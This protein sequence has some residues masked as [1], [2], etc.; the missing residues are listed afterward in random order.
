MS[1]HSF[2]VSV[3]VVA[4][5]LFGGI[6]A[7]S[8]EMPSH[9]ELPPSLEISLFAQEPDI[10]DPVAICFDAASRMFVVEMRDYPLGIPPKNEPGGTIRLLEDTDHDGHADRS[11]LFADHLSYPTSIVPFRDGVIVAAPPEIILLRDTNHDGKAD[12]REVLCRGFNRRATDSNTSGLRWG[13]DNWLHGVNGG[14]GGDIVSTRKPA[15]ALRLGNLDFRMR[16]DSGEIET[17]FTTGGGFGLVFDQWGR[18]FTPH[19]VNHV[20]MRIMAERW[21]ERNPGLPPTEGT[22][23][24]SD[25]EEMSRIYAISQAQ[26]RPNHPEQAGYFSAAGAIG[27]IGDE[28]YPDDLASSVT[29]AD[30]VGNLIHRDVLSPDGPILKASRAT[31]EQ[32]SEFLASTDPA[33]RPTALELGPDG[34]L[35][36]ADMQRD[37]IEHPDFIPKTMLDKLDLRAGAD[38]GRIY[39]IFP[40]RPLHQNQ[41]TLASMTPAELVDEL[42]S[43]NQWRRMTAQRLIVENNHLVTTA[44]LENIVKQGTN[45]IARAQALWTLQGLGELGDSVLLAALDDTNPRVV[46]NAV[47]VATAFVDQSPAVRDRVQKLAIDHPDVRV[48]FLAAARVG[49]STDAVVQIL[50]RD[51]EYRWS[52]LA[53]LSALKGG[54]HIVLRDL[55][56]QRDSLPAGGRLAVYHDLANLTAARGSTDALKLVI[57]A[58]PRSDAETISEVLRDLTEGLGRRGNLGSET[59]TLNDS[60]EALAKDSSLDQQRAVW[61]LEDRLGLPPSQSQNTAIQSALQ[62]AAND[63]QSPAVRRSSIELLALAKPQQFVPT[64]LPLFS[65]VTTPEIQRAALDILRRPTDV[66]I[67]RGLIDRWPEIHPSLK[68][69]VTSLLLSRR[70]YHGVLLDAIEDHRIKVG[71]LNLDLEDRRRLIAWSSPEIQERARKLIGDGEYGNRQAKVSEWLAKL[72]DT[73][74]AA[75]GRLVFEQTC[76]P[77]HRIGDIGHEVG[78][79]LTGVSHRSVEDLVSNILDPNMAINPNYLSVSVETKDG[80]LITGILV[81]ETSEAVTLLQPQGIRTTLRRDQISRQESTGTSLMPEG[82]EATM[83]PVDLRNLVAFLQESR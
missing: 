63:D 39:R 51:S 13:L 32:T 83:Q 78:P 79:N 61:Q 18:S 45:A 57:D 1:T 73:G 44:P 52:R 2:S 67:A 29:V 15:E 58:L 77:C 53:A 49:L 22:H 35:Y 26:T 16:P 82:L 59:T 30:M 76:S 23:S 34:A 3:L 33:F 55:L 31:G 71:E 10:V 42:S 68:R 62:T 11:V 43:P 6:A 80:E 48:R 75:K 46:E 60:L 8:A 40:K 81:A 14:N 20:Q 19:N 25:H 56:E 28:E 12:V 27:F 36:L 64:L 21:L 17:T 54:E 37:V 38:R 66:A 24:I 4:T 74:N 69:E 65:G 50:K 72:P 70:A 41:K 47:E 5:G 9:I 7:R